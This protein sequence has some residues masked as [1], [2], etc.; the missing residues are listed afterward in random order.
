MLSPRFIVSF[1]QFHPQPT[2]TSACLRSETQKSETEIQFI[3][4]LSPRFIVSFYQFHPKPTSTSTSLGSETLKNV[5]TKG[6]LYAVTRFACSDSCI[7]SA[8]S[9]LKER[10]LGSEDQNFVHEF[11]SN[12]RNVI[13]RDSIILYDARILDVIGGLLDPRDHFY[14]PLSYSLHEI[15]HHESVVAL[16]ISYPRMRGTFLQA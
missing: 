11:S 3:V 14:S 6:F 10:S 15:S 8:T 9:N 12:F 1:Y 7:K 13:V 2:S 5:R 16:E 4:V